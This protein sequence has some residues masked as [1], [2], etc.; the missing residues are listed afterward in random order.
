MVGSFYTN[1]SISVGTNDFIT[2]PVTVEKGVLQGDSLSPL[3]FNMCFNALT[4]TIENDKIKAYGDIITHN[5]ALSPLHWFQFAD[6]IALATA[7]Q[8]D[9]QSLLNIFSKWCQ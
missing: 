1:Y 5:Y 8:E 9:S 2:N 4:R 7:T 6:D 3:I